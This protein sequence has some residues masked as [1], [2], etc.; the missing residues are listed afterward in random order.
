MNCTKDEWMDDCMDRRVCVWF[1]FKIKKHKFR[2]KQIS[3]FA[4]IKKKREKIS[5]L[6]ISR[7]IVCDI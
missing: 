2:K 4:K 5:A 3:N 1:V 6:F 7:R